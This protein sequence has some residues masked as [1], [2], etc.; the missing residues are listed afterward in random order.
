MY[1]IKLSNNLY[2][3]TT[4]NITLINIKIVAHKTKSFVKV[5]LKKL[6]GGKG[7]EL[8]KRNAKGKLKNQL[9]FDL[10]DINNVLKWLKV[11]AKYLDI[12]KNVTTHVGRNS[13]SEILRNDYQIPIDIIKEM[14]GHTTIKMTEGYAK[15]DKRGIENVIDN[16]TG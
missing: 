7:Y 13:F 5:P 4:R 10:P 1:F 9:L 11:M 14:M 3:P 12:D 6:F 16:L 15:M 2:L 8:A